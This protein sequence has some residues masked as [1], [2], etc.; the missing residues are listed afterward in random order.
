MPKK[1]TKKVTKKSSIYGPGQTFGRP[2]KF[3]TVQ[4][5][6]AAINAYFES[7]FERQAKLVPV[8]DKD[9]NPVLNAKGELMRKWV[10]VDVQVRPFTVSALAVELGMSRTH[11]LEYETLDSR[12]DFGDSVKKARNI[13]LAYAEKQLFTGQAVAGVIFNL[14]NNYG[15][16]NKSSEELEKE[17]SQTVINNTTQTLHLNGQRPEV[18]NAFKELLGPSAPTENS[19]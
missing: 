8:F 17:K 10:S 1:K 9:G 4:E 5:F 3:R 13:C 18:E 14:I 11:F 15:W 16:K 12:K 6:D 19:V 2:R 7:C